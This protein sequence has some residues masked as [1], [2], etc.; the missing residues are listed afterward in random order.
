MGQH[1]E[2]WNNTVNHNQKHKTKD[3]LRPGRGV[4]LV[5][6]DGELLSLLQ[7]HREK[8]PQDTPAE[9]D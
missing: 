7:Q 9:N 5:R 1:P 8:L 6:G 3:W 2:L 4:D